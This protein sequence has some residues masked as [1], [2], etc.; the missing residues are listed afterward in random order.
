MRIMDGYMN[1][2][3]YIKKYNIIDAIVIMLEY[4]L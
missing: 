4:S 2:Y 1:I 3:G